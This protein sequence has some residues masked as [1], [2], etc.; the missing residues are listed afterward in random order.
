MEAARV[1]EPSLAFS[2]RFLDRAVDPGRDFYEFATG[3][4]RKENPVPSDQSAWGAFTELRRHNRRQLREIAE[5]AK[6]ASASGPSPAQEVGT[7]YA[8]ALDRD[9]R[10]EL[11]FDPPA[12]YLASVE[13][14][15]TPRDLLRVLAELHDSGFPG[16]FFTE[17]DSD[18]KNS[19]T[20]AFYLSQGGLSL[21]DREYYLA[22]AFAA[23]REAYRRHVHRMFEL[24]G[25]T[26]GEGERAAET[27]FGLEQQLARASR[28]R[29][30]T[31]DV[32][33][34][35]HRLSVEELLARYPS[36][37]WS[38]YLASRK[39][40]VA[41]YVIVRQPEFFDAVDKL[42]VPRL[43]EEWKVYLRWNILHRAAPTLHADADREDFAFFH[44]A[45]Q[46]Q[47][48]PEPDWERA[49]QATDELLGEALGQLY[50]ERYFPPE[51][52]RR[53]DVLVSDLMTVFHDRLLHLDWMTEPTRKKALE[54]FS[55]F[56]PMIGNPV[57][58]R[59]YSSIVLEHNA[60]ASNCIRAW[61]FDIRRR[62]ARLGG[63]VDREEW[64]M[65]PPT[66]DA[67]H[68][69][70]QLHIVF[71]AGILQPPFFD[72]AM[73][74]AV[75]YGSIGAVIGHEITHGFDDQGRR[76]DAHG[77][78]A[79]WWT[80][81]DAREFEA[82]AVQVEKEY[83]QLEALPGVHVDGKLTLGEN[84]ADIGGVSIAFEALQHRLAADPS[85][86]NTIDGFTPTQRFCLAW[87]Q[88]WR[89]NVREEEVRRRAT[90]DPHS[91][92]RFR[93][94]VPLTH[95]P[96]FFEAFPPSATSERARATAPAI[97]IW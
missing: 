32:E 78:M 7:F 18:M 15:A 62:M 46:G 61:K 75:N 79:D 52:R 8:S 12:P 24:W 31:R 6:E 17:V 16:V 82:R 33:K 35:Y 23:T 88:T 3:M 54:K 43:V 72:V 73:D 22:D 42:I 66:V 63:P 81:A 11:A 51:A 91:P 13:S 21:P 67:Y 97:R 68:E 36:I 50:V 96:E 74:D 25:R 58:Y 76:F 1:D 19:S 55:R 90:I 39:A 47:A 94:F 69:F 14:I 60:F 89:A 44:R 4:W 71:P 77:N 64:W 20:Y 87:A 40:G 49:V 86:A 57:R 5:A 10:N 38:E 93:G 80:E 59:D 37:P 28:T 2:V 92:P 95:L 56:V 9:R 85:R 70:T 41:G 53:M 65:T 27:V 34:N 30:E 45:L 83:G 29:A 26:S 48:E 84:I